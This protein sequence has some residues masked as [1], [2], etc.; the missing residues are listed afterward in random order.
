RP[1][2][3]PPLK[4]THATPLITTSAGC[5]RPSVDRARFDAPDSAYQIEVSERRDRGHVGSA[6][7]TR[8]TVSPC[9][10]L[11][12]FISGSGEVPARQSRSTG[13]DAQTAVAAAIASRSS[14]SA[15]NSS[16]R[17]RRAGWGRGRVGRVARQPTRHQCGTAVVRVVAGHVG[18]FDAPTAGEAY[19]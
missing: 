8:A 3:Q 9:A 1:P 16:G 14:R 5:L 2:P 18:Y 15:S 13:Q 17:P 6:A 19:S 12:D 11:C 7:G 4:R 10:Y